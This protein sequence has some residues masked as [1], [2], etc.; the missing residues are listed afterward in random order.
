[1]GGSARASSG[2]LRLALLALFAAGLLLIPAA[3]A[4]ADFTLT[5][6]FAGTG[7]GRLE[8]EVET[9]EDFFAEEC[10]EEEVEIPEGAEV[11]IVP[12]EESGSE[13]VEFTEDCGPLACELIMDDDHKVIAI[14]DLEPVEE[15]ALTIGTNGTGTGTVEC[16]LET[17]PEQCEDFYPEEAEVALIPVPGFGSEFVEFSGDCP[18]PDECELFMDEDHAV[19]ATF[20]LESGFEPELTINLSGTG[21]GTIECEVEGFVEGCEAKYPGGTDVVLVATPDAGSE[22][23]GYSGACSGS[24]CAL[25]MNANHDVTAT[26]NLESTSGGGGGGS[27]GSGSGGTVTKPPAPVPGKLGVSGAALFQGGKAVL[28][29]SCKGQGP[30]KGSLKLVAK[31]KVGKAKAKNIVIGQ[32]S[33]SLAAGT[34]RTLKVKLAG[35]AKKVLG[36][37][38][39]VKATVSGTGVTK[40]TV[41]IKP[42][43][44]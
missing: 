35:A 8:C 23:A 18:E 2:G 3:Q 6:E 29:L 20:D 25:T 30:C 21:G 42:T 33:F 5:I 27:G 14:F 16:E 31:L 13:F 38:K 19:T 12:E 28:R 15:F 17:G 7:E 11:R 34:S 24:T 41:T 37:A 1:M 32:A 36:K 43:A 40:S 4:S 22:F 44:R 9:E 26:F 39:N 10:G